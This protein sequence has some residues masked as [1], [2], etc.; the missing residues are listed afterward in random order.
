MMPP[1]LKSGDM[2]QI[3]SP[4]SAIHPS[5]VEGAKRTLS[6]WNLKVLE[7]KYA[8]SAYGRFAGTKE[9]RIFD[10]QQALDDPEVKAIFMSRGGYGLVQ[11]ID[12]INFEQFKV[13]IKGEEIPMA[14]K[15]FEL[16]ALLASKPGKVFKRNEIMSRVWGEE[17]IV[18]DRTI[19]VHIRKLREKLG[20]EYISTMKG[21]GY[22]L[23]F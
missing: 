3:V 22:K 13:L 14:K 7:G 6:E 18:G 9:E 2:V 12:K 17:V 16:L 21:V 5:Y 15:E 4:A 11:I 23:D 10:L 8:R 1:F 20:D 19:D